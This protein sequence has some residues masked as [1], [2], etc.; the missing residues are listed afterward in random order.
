MKENGFTL[1]RKAKSKQHHA[2][3]ITDSDYA[4]NLALRA[5]S[6]T[7]AECLMHTLEQAAW[8]IGLYVISGK[9]VC[10]FWFSCEDGASPH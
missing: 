4:D 5:N 10:Y 1:K 2:E 3:T 9:R 8:V 6:S 7:Q